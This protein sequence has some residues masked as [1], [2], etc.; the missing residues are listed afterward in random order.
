MS[1]AEEQKKSAGLALRSFGASDDHL[2]TTTNLDQLF[3]MGYVAAGSRSAMLR[4]A[5]SL[6]CID[7]LSR[8]VART[9][10]YLYRRKKGGAE[11]VEPTEHPVA[12]ILATR[13]SRYYGIK[14]FKRITTSYLATASQYYVAARRN[15][16]GDIMEVQG[17]PHTDVTTRV[18]P[19]ARRYVYDITANGLHAQAQYGWAE[20]KGGLMDDEIAH[21][22]LRSFNGYDAVAT[23]NVAK[24]AFEL[25]NHMNKFQGDLFNNGGMPIL[26]ITFP[27]GLTDEQW[28][29]LN[30]DLQ[31][32]AK[33]SRE[34]GVPFILEGANGESPK[35]EKMSL[36]AVD[37]EFLKANTAAMM[38]ICRFYGVPPHKAYV[39]DSVKY[40]NLD[41]IE[42][43]YV[44]D[45]LVPIFDA[46]C[47][48][49]MPVLLTEDEQAKYFI[50]FDKEAAYASDPLSRQKVVESRWKNGQIEYDE[51]REAIGY[52][53][54]G[55]DIG[56]QRMFSG[57]FVVVDKD[58]NVVMKA[59]GNTPGEE[60]TS[61][62]DDDE[63]KKPKKDGDEK[64]LRLVQ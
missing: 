42:R 4:L 56:R 62:L 27:E 15:G 37:T 35:V 26:G 12:R 25:L 10:M 3:S 30:K 24:A 63:Q 41:S 64:R 53:A 34:K 40:D 6:K 32:Q 44:D 1:M 14:E 19:R 39:F 57:N 61:A 9:P 22:R 59:G 52:N 54:A 11:I 29:R 28:E 55:G 51:M 50:E 58:G 48:A 36:T 16:G 20:R 49:I 13:T 18:E 45:S 21:I 8:D 46:I 5:V 7:V 31:A 23:S 17:I 33:K 38:D 60:E 47:E 2:W 43:L